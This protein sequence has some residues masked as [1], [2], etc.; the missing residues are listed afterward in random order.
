[1]YW[2]SWCPGIEK[3]NGGAG[4][5]EIVTLGDVI[6]LLHIFEEFSLEEEL[7]LI[8]ILPRGRSK[9]KWLKGTK[10]F[11]TIRVEEL[12]LTVCYVCVCLCSHVFRLMYRSW[13]FNLSTV[14]IW[15][16]IMGTRGRPSCAL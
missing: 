9:T 5:G 11:L 7:N 15:S 10:H 13:S 2:K 16:Q 1:M 6:Y 4:F 12:C 8:S 14:D 3:G